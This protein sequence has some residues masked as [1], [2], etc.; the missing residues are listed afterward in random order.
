MAA[1]EVMLGTT[2]IRNLIR[3]N[4]LSQIPVF[5]EN[6]QEAGMKPLHKELERLISEGTITAEEALMLLP[7]IKEADLTAIRPAETKQTIIERFNR[8]IKEIGQG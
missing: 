8:A 5:M 2:A 1:F 3:E 4:K 7:G 6:G